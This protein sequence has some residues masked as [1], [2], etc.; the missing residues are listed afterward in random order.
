MT[1]ETFSKIGRIYCKTIEWI[2]AVIIVLVA[3][4]MLEMVVSRTFDDRITCRQLSG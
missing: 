1:L 2:A 3:L 4:A